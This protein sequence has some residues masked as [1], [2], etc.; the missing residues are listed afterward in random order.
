MKSF[1]KKCAASV[2]VA[3]IATASLFSPVMA[4]DATNLFRDMDPTTNNGGLK[5]T[6]NAGSLFRNVITIVFIVAAILTLFYLVMGAIN[7]I[8][9]GG[10]KGKVEDARNK[11]TAAVIGLLLLAATWAIYQL[12]MTVAFG[13]DTQGIT[14]PYLAR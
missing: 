14:I 7:W 10:D 3:T 5:I 8:T 2:G 13:T 1:L 12:V 11:I 6:G 9:S 4:E